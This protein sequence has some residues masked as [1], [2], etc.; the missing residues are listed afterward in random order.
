MADD[1][2]EVQRPVFWP[3]P[4]HF[5]QAEIEADEMWSV[6]RIPTRV[7]SGAL[8]GFMLTDDA[9]HFVGQQRA[10]DLGVWDTEEEVIAAIEEHHRQQ[11]TVESEIQPIKTKEKPHA[12]PPP[13]GKQKQRA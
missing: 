13:K 3:G 10:I 8:V 9:L 1:E 4:W 2:A 12:A 5:V 6:N 7:T 11:A